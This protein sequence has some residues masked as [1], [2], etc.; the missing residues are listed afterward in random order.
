[1]NKKVLIS[2]ALLIAL[3]APL[4]YAHRQWLLP[5]ST[6]LSGDS[7]WVTFDSVRSN[8][9]FFANHSA[10]A[11]DSVTVTGPDGETVEIHNGIEGEIRTVF[12]VELTKQ[13]TYLVSSG[14]KGFRAFWM[15]GEERRRWAG[16]EVE[17]I[18]QGLKE[19]KDLRLSFSHSPVVSYVTLGAPS[20]KVLEPKGECIEI[21]FEETHPNDLYEAETSNFI[22][23]RYGV[24][25]EG[26][27]VRIVKGGDRYR[28]DAGETVFKTGR[29]GRFSY[30]WPAAGAYWM[31]ISPP[32]PPRS[33]GGSDRS[34]GG[35]SLDG[36]PYR[37]S[38][39]LT[40]TLEVL[41]Q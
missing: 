4:S 36:I 41:P 18:S 15:E 19:K 35:E 31:N 34:A 2:C 17:F 10:P 38:V 12:D 24:P 30:V 37:R 7:A 14:H 32:R 22:V 23:H 29:D 39:S 11:L 25:A 33:E 3:M 9:I 8:N 40:A 13:G 1:M 6:V 21:I 5:S 28:N 16:T 20:T 27:E 26:L